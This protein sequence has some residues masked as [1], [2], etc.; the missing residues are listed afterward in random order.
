MEKNEIVEQ[1]FEELKK[2]VTE[3]I[4]EVLNN[5][6]KGEIGI[7]SYLSFDKD[8]VTAGE[9]SEHLNVSTAR[10]ASILNSLEHKGYISRNEDILDRRK[11]I[12]NIT[13]MGKELASKAKDDIFAK[14][15]FI[16]SELGE[17]DAKEYI[18]ILI[19]I[20]NILSNYRQ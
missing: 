3:S 20:K 1:I 19:K 4:S 14:I 7:L 8:G 15:T 6:T 13:D 10:I 2:N 12:V 11:I 18:R 9:L 17:E 16:I 5:F